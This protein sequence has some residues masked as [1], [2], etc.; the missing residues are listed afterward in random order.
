MA[1]SLIWQPTPRMVR[2]MAL[3]AQR[4]GVVHVADMKQLDGHFRR[5]LNGLIRR[6]LAEKA[7]AAL[8][9]MGDSY[10]LTPEGMRQGAAVAV[11]VANSTETEIQQC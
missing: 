11:A 2:L 10:R 3:M 1:K 6:G 8:S 7:V 4:G 9:P 5:Y